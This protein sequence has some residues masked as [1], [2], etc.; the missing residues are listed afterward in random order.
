MEANICHFCLQ[1]LHILPSEYYSLPKQERAFIV[2]SCD[3]TGKARDK[4]LKEYQ[5]KMRRGHK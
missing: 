4:E 2:A 1:E 3:L 5:A